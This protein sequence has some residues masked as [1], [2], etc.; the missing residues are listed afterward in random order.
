MSQKAR[1]A[2]SV[3]D[4]MPYEIWSMILE[5]LEAELSSQSWARP[6]TQNDPQNTRTLASVSGVSE[7]AHPV[8]NQFLYRTLD[9]ESLEKPRVSTVSLL[10]AF[11][12]QP[13][14]GEHVQKLR[15]NF[16]KLV[17]TTKDD[18][19]WDELLK[20]LERRIGAG[21]LRSEAKQ[22]LQMWVN[23]TRQNKDFPDIV[24]PFVSL[25]PRLQVLECQ[26]KRWDPLAGNLKNCPSL[27]E[28]RLK[29]ANETHP[30]SIAEI[31]PALM[32]PTLKV[33]RLYG[34]GS[35]KKFGGNLWPNSSVETVD[36]GDSYLN[37]DGVSGIFQLFP[38]LKN[39]SYEFGSVKRMKDCQRAQITIGELGDELRARGKYLESL[40]IDTVVL[41]HFPDA[42]DN[43]TLGSFKGLESLK[44]LC[45]C[46]PCLI[47][48]GYG[49]DEGRAW[50][51]ALPSQLESIHF[52][53]ELRVT[54][55]SFP[56]RKD[57]ELLKFV[58]K[59]L[60]SN[61]GRLRSLKKVSVELHCSKAQVH[62]E[63][64]NV[65]EDYF[66]EWKIGR[67]EEWVSMVPTILYG[68][69]FKP[70]I[71]EFIRS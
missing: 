63:S 45:V 61:E 1:S 46:K 16:S 42:D 50:E 54:S 31:L 58:R 12:D 15:V 27:T 29:A 56:P 41:L 62:D 18:I 20:S 21:G 36:L 8:A 14:L 35:E 13:I 52:L 48:S 26:M 4:K 34:F 24:T 53:P 44:H 71:V 43:R 30:V 33:V 9:L 37:K 55:A 23:T 7:A 70:T 69:K 40:T 47:K 5:P 2:S 25:L 10:R 19:K 38:K 68:E 39:F 11:A 28:V 60:L 67:K 59:Y 3:E 32:H 57:E 49:Q 22:C 66:G 17:A 6:M 65:V 51:N 64:G